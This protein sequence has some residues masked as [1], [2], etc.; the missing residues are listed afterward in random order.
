MHNILLFDRNERPISVDAL[1]RIFRSVAGF[2][3]VRYNTPIGTPIEADYAEDDD[4]TTVRLDSE[5]ETIS[6][7]GTSDAA[8][9]A[10]WILQLQLQTPLRIVDTDYSFDL[11][12]NDFKS[13][14]ELQAAIDSARAS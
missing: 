3:Q 8:L 11:V 14:E 6:I 5:R 12:L 7:S 10:A 4:S 1:D 9:Q 2:G 13:L